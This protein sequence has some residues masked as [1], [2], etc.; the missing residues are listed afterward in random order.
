M[1]PMGAS[2]RRMVLMMSWV[3]LPLAPTSRSN[4]RLACTR[5]FSTARASSKTTVAC[6]TASP[7]ATRVTAVSTGRKDRFWSA[8]RS[9]S[10]VR[11][12]QEPFAVSA[13]PYRSAATG[14]DRG[15]PPGGW[16]CWWP[17]PGT[18]ARARPHAFRDR[19][20]RSVHRPGARPG[21]SPTPWRPPLSAARLYL[22]PAASAAGGLPGRGR[23]GARAPYHGAHGVALYR[24]RLARDGH[25]R[26]H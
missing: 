17:P 6:A 15:W 24:T 16:H 21:H 18:G 23:A 1:L 11:R 20:V 12:E 4:G 10:M 13:Q 5:P 8:T 22:M 3:G 7:T 2:R 25:Y 26:A 9:A 19:H 14:Y